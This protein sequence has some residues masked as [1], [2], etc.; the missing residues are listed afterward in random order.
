MTDTTSQASNVV[1]MAEGICQ[2]GEQTKAA[3]DLERARQI[4]LRAFEI[5]GKQ[6]EKDALRFAEQMV[7][8]EVPLARR[9]QLA[10]QA[11]GLLLAKGWLDMLTAPPAEGENGKNDT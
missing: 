8:G 7:L 11:K 9:L 6:L 1:P 10:E 3:D 2:H 4:T 5:T